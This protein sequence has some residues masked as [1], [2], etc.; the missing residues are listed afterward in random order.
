MQGVRRWIFMP[1]VL[2]CPKPGSSENAGQIPQGN[3]SLKSTLKDIEPRGCLWDPFQS[4]PLLL[5]LVMTRIYET[6]TTYHVKGVNK[7]KRISEISVE[8]LDYSLTFLQ[9]YFF[10]WHSLYLAEAR[11]LHA[12]RKGH[13]FG[14]VMVTIGLML[15]AQ[16]LT[17]V[18]S[19]G[20]HNSAENLN[21][22]VAT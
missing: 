3:T 4:S 10:L 9:K 5:G 12:D 8:S 14:E 22:E 7:K 16:S 18:G 13:V 21:L 15:R 20:V 19:K 11:R 17:L 1:N 6:P 2:D